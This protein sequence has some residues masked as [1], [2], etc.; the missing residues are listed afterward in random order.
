MPNTEVIAAI[1]ANMNLLGSDDC[2]C[3][4]CDKTNKGIS[5]DDEICLKIHYVSLLSA[6]DDVDVIHANDIK[7]HDIVM[8]IPVPR[9]SGEKKYALFYNDK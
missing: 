1:I 2:T 7:P 9:C 6:S 3:N 8:N 5:E 4:I